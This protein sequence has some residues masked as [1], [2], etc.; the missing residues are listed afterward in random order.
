V[1][2][3]TVNMLEAKSTLSRLVSDVE[4]GKVAEVVI[5]RN[6]RPAARIVPLAPAP[7]VRLGLAKG[8]FSVPAS[9]DSGNALVAALF[10]GSASTDGAGA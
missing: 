4:S 5:A 1:I 7:K 10:E 8:Q 3:V 6:G 9:I 2:D